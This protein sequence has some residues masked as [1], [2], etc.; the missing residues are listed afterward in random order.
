METTLI[1]ALITAAVTMFGW[2][3]SNSFSRYRDDRTR[4]LEQNI[5]RYQQQLEEFYG[6]LF[7]LLH[8]TIIYNNV[9]HEIVFHKQ[10]FEVKR[11]SNLDEDTSLK[12][13]KYFDENHFIKLHDEINEILK[14][15]LYLIVDG[16]VPDSIIEYMR[17]SYQERVQKQLWNELGVSTN[18]LQGK[19][20]PDE[21]LEDIK[22]GINTVQKRLG[23]ALQERE[24]KSDLSRSSPRKS[25]KNKKPYNP[26][27]LQ[28]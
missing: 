28:V 12:I 5:K 18:Y 26:E 3:V 15:K 10:D 25:S 9:A 23:N 27:T 11:R 6:P 22:Q 4:R 16:K 2:I 20:F 8:Q 7:N 24:V 13:Q 1:I 21:F 14:R 19:P 17:H